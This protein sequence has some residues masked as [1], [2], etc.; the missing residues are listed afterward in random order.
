MLC[1]KAHIVISIVKPTRCAIFFFFFNIT[2]HVSDGLPVHYQEFKTVHTAS[3]IYHTEIPKNITRTLCEAQMRPHQISEKQFT[4]QK[5]TQYILHNARY[6]ICKI[7]IHVAVKSP[8]F[9][10]KYISLYHP[11][12]KYVA[13][14]SFQTHTLCLLL[15]TSTF[16]IM[17]GEF[18]MYY[19][20]SL[21][22][23]IRFTFK[24]KST[25]QMHQSLKFIA[26][27]SNTAQHV[28]GILLPIIKNYYWVY[29][30]KV[31][32]CKK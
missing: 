3:V 2:L 21:F 13:Y 25:I 9:S 15:K 6:W 17:S 30:H 22:Q 29:K 10:R 8:F 5:L 27:R 19:I 23:K 11:F 20:F 18:H 28:S 26:R 1:T 12:F 31:V 32:K 14:N 16:L 24:H 7:L 4:T